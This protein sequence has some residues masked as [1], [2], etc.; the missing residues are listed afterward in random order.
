MT[1]RVWLLV[2]QAGLCAPAL[3]GCA[4]LSYFAHGHVDSGDAGHGDAGS[5]DAQQSP[6]PQVQGGQFPGVEEAEPA[7]AAPRRPDVARLTQLGGI[8]QTRKPLFVPGP[9]QAVKEYTDPPPVLTP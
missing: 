8:G 7:V 5:A 6:G 2:L 1:R 9:G 3:P 4:P